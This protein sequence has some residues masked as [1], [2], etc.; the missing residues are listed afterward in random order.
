MT[1]PTT[2]DGTVRIDRDR[3]RATLMELKEIGA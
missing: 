3:L 2:D 1:E